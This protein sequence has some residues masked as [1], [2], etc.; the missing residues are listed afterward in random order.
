M[1]HVDL[2]PVGAMIELL[3]RRLACF[4]WA[5]NKLCALRHVELRG[6]ALQ[7]ITARSGDGAGRD[8]QARPRNIALV[9]SLLDA[10]PAL[11]STLGLS[12]SSRRKPLLRCPPS[13][14]RRS[15]R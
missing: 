11:T 2:D 8:K 6:V 15:C 14:D 4:D 10:Q 12:G 3:P 13:R 7:R 9:A 1:R 5:V